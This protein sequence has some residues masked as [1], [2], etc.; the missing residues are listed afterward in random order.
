MLIVMG[1]VIVIREMV[2]NGDVTGGGQV[3]VTARRYPDAAHP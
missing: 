3:P 2:S 1:M